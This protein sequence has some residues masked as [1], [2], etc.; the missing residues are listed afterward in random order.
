MIAPDIILFFNRQHEIMK[1]SLICSVSDVD[2]FV[3][4]KHLNVA[5]QLLH[6][7]L[8]ALL[9]ILLWCCVCDHTKALILIL[10]VLPVGLK[11]INDCLPLICCKLSQCS[12]ANLL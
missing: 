7:S 2:D 9:A 3:L 4:F 10:D 8:H 6:L 1:K 12:T 11:P 5:L